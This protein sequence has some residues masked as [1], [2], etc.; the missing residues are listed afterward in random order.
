MIQLNTEY[1]SKIIQYKLKII[2]YKQRI[3][4]YKWKRSNIAT[5]DMPYSGGS[6]DFP[7]GGFHP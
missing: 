5:F 7:K 2:Q 1:K 6:R 3:I 4:K